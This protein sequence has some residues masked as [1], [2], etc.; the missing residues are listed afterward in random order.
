MTSKVSP[1]L[2]LSLSLYVLS[3]ETRKA[4]DFMLVSCCSR[5]ALSH[6]IL[7]D[8]NVLFCLMY[9][10]VQKLY[11]YVSLHALGNFENV[12]LLCDNLNFI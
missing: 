10:L 9:S 2:T 3:T 8:L 12:F 4:I 6:A 11:S 5:Y 7:P 1:D